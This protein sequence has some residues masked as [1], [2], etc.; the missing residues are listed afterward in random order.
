MKRYD[1]EDIGFGGEQDKVM[2]EDPEGEWGKYIDWLQSM[3]K[4]DVKDGDVVVLKYTMTLSPSAY[5]HLKE[6]VQ[7][8]LKGFGFDIHVILIEDGMEIGLLRKEGDSP[9]DWSQYGEW[10][11][12]EIP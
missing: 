7:E 1:L 6:G 4:L 9:I 10:K 2:T 5:K 11:K 8:M 12:K 3:Q